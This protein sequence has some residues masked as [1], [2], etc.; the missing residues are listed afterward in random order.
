MKD[1][2]QPTIASP[3]EPVVSCE[4]M[5]DLIDMLLNSC[6]KY[7]GDDRFSHEHDLFD[8]VD[9]DALTSIRNKLTNSN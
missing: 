2:K 9:R 8:S 3:I 6:T 4:L 5:I 1:E 7:S